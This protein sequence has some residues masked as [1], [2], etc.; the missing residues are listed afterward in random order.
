MLDDIARAAHSAAERSALEWPGGI[1]TYRDLETA[2]RRACGS[3]SDAGVGAGDRVGLWAAP[4][5]DM[6]AALWAVPRLGASMVPLNTRWTPG[7]AVQ[8][9]SD[10][11]CR[12]VIVDESAPELDADLLSLEALSQGDEASIEG[13]HPVQ[14]WYVVFTSGSAGSARGVSLTGTNIV[15]A[16][17]ASERRLGNGRDDRWLAVLP[18]FHVGGLSI[19]WRSARAAGTVVLDAFDRVGTAS[20]FHGDVT[21]ASLVPTMLR[22][23]IDTGQRFNGLRAV[24]VGGGPLDP[25]LAAEASAAGLPVVATYGMTEMASQVATQR[26]GDGDAGGPLPPLEGVEV[27]VVGDDG[28]PLPAGE[29]GM[30]EVRGPMLS[31][32]YVDGAVIEGWLRTSDQ[33]RLDEAGNVAVEGRADWV[34]NSGGEK[35]SPEPIEAML[36]AHPAVAAVA[37]YG[38]PHSERGETVAAAVVATSGPMPSEEELVAYLAERLASLEIPRSWRFVD[39]LPRTALGKLDRGALVGE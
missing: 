5:P 1:L 24:L 14:P 27:R 12:F 30:I 8:A 3:L 11:D 32:G 36:E 13:A 17:E 33:G 37:V 26:P 28:S 9:A 4:G 35:I 29:P 22:R 2:V 6:V 23:L 7:Q 15:A 39:E 19:L 31:P 20:R 10:A 21:F 18:L 38:E 34:I 25:G 16:V